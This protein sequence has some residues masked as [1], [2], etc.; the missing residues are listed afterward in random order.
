MAVGGEYVGGNSFGWLLFRGMA[1]WGM[2]VCVAGGWLG[3]STGRVLVGS[4]SV[5]A[6][7]VRGVSFG[8]VSWGCGSCGCVIQ[9]T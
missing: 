4:V 1:V 7:A 9:T 5:G 2:C 6:V 8:G 3:V